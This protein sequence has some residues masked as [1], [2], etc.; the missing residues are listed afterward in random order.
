MIMIM[1]MMMTMMKRMIT[2]RFLHPQGHQTGGGEIS[3]EDDDE[4]DVTDGDDD[5]DD[6]DD[7]NSDGND[8]FFLQK[9]FF[10]GI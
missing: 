7:D 3:Y 1:M 5:V 2:M 10:V 4:I 6:N 9:H 8:V